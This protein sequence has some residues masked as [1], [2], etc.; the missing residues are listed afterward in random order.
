MTGGVAGRLASSELDSAAVKAEQSK[1]T[2]QVQQA[3]EA[4]GFEE[5]YKLNFL[6]NRMDTV[7][8]MDIAHELT[9]HV[10]DYR[11]D[12]MFTHHPGDYNWDHTSTFDAVMMAAR[13]N[14]PDHF[15]SEV[16]TFEVLSSTERAWQ[17]GGRAFMSNCY[18]DV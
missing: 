14:P 7:S 10:Q 13:A 18:F 2:V 6:D 5:V 4:I 1:L 3:A 12:M 16:R 11:P 15:P 17:N 8:R 9:P